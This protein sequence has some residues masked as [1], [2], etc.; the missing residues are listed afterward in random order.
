MNRHLY[1]RKTRRFFLHHRQSDRQQLMR[2]AGQ[3]LGLEPLTPRSFSHERLEDPIQRHVPP[4][5]DQLESLERFCR[6]GGRPTDSK[7]ML[8]ANGSLTLEGAFAEP[9]QYFAVDESKREYRRAMTGGAADRLH[10][11]DGSVRI[12]L[13]PK[14]VSGDP[15]RVAESGPLR[16][17]GLATIGQRV[18]PLLSRPAIGTVSSQYEAR[19]PDDVSKVLQKSTWKRLF[20]FT[21]SLQPD[22]WQR[23][24]SARSVSRCKSELMLKRPD[25]EAVAEYY[26]VKKIKMEQ[27]RLQ[28]TMRQVQIRRRAELQKLQ[29]RRLQRELLEMRSGKWQQGTPAGSNVLSFEHDADEGL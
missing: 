4:P 14:V 11:S 7:L 20:A 24:A 17:G 8:I 21:T 2:K 10:M 28:E 12:V 25:L 13:A 26:T 19:P 6:T 23:T 1:E 16:D 18:S 27:Q 9:Q 15:A 3:I 5:A 22:S 29:D